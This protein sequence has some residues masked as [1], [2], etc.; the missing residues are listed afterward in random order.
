[1]VVFGWAIRKVWGQVALELH[2]EEKS[3]ILQRERES[4]VERKGGSSEWY[5]NKGMEKRKHETPILC[6][7]PKWPGSG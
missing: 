6:L 7:L 4:L 1:M 3:Q 5:T 2:L